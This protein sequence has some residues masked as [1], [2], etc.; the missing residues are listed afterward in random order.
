MTVGV[1][2][3][4]WLLY[5]RKEYEAYRRLGGPQDWSGQMQKILPSARFDPRTIQPV[6][7]HYTN[8]AIPAHTPVTIYYIFLSVWF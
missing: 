1:N 6:V 3:M 5:L 2:T 4:P 7:S 8:Y